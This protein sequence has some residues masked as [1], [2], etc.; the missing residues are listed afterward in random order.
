MTRRPTIRRQTSRRRIRTAPHPGVFY[1]V[2]RKSKNRKTG[3]IVTTYASRY[4]CPDSCPLKRS[5]CYADGF[6]GNLHWNHV[7][8]GR[9]GKPLAEHCKELRAL[10]QSDTVRLD[11]AGDLPGNGVKIHLRNALRLL[12]AASHKGRQAFTYT[13]Y[14]A[15]LDVL[16][17]LNEL[18]GTVVS[19]S[20]NNPTE[21]DIYLDAGLPTVTLLPID[22]KVTQ[23]PKGK[24]IATC[25]AVLSD[26]VTCATCGNG[27]PLCARRDRNYVVGFPV[28][29]SA[30]RKANLIAT[31]RG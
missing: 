21:A 25:P 22:I 4:N 23:T 17:K 18:T 24:R 13:H 29:G 14:T 11:V 16:K 26:T 8:A 15:D 10:P 28:H 1:S 5:G 20:A 7:T 3:P 6:P 2:N 9:R 12:K 19:A 30:F 27:K 31:E